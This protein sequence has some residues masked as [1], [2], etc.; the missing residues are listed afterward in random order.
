MTTYEP[1]YVYNALW[2]GA[3]CSGRA[4]WWNS[5]SSPTCVRRKAL[6]DLC[7]T[8]EGV[9][10]GTCVYCCAS[11]VK[12]EDEHVFPSSWYPD[13]TPPSTMLI[14]PACR[15]CNGDFGRVEER[16]FLTLAMTLPTS[17]AKLLDR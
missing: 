4:P 1:T 7:A 15:R 10:L 16:M 17:P 3:G 12:V 2:L 11:P 5:G 14:V 6:S 8:V 13:G 9:K